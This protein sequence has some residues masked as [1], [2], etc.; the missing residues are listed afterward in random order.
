MNAAC[1]NTPGS[2]KCD[3]YDGYHGNG[4]LCIALPIAL[5]RIE[6]AYYTKNTLSCISTSQHVSYPTNAPGY[7]VDPTGYF[8]T[9]GAGNR[10][11]VT[12]TECKI[13]C[14]MSD[15]CTSFYFDPIQGSCFL[16]KDE[17]PYVTSNING[18]TDC[19]REDCSAPNV[20]ICEKEIYQKNSPAPPTRKA[21]VSILIR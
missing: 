7:V 18:C 5:T 10:V 16:K 13:A 4:H 1:I 17:C 9:V 8:P 2:Y 6:K 12:L 14:H 19:G 20:S 15:E 3:C 21:L 11:S